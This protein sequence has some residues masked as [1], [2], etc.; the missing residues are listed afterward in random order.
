MKIVAILL[1]GILILLAV[2]LTRST[3]PLTES[4]PDPVL[5]F[6]EAL[7][8][9]SLDTVP[10]LAVGGDENRYWYIIWSVRSAALMQDS[11]LVSFDEVR[12]IIQSYD[13]N[14]VH[15]VTWGAEG[16]G[17]GEFKDIRS[18]V[19]PDGR[20][21]V[22]DGGNW[23]FTVFDSDG[24][25]E[26]DFA[27]RRLREIVPGGAIRAGQAQCRWFGSRW[28]ESETDFL[29]S[30]P[31]MGSVVECLPSGQD[32]LVTVSAVPVGRWMVN[33]RGQMVPMQMSMERHRRKI[34]SADQPM[35]VP[36]VPGF[37]VPPASTD[38]RAPG[39]SLPIINGNWADPT[40][41]MW[42]HLAGHTVIY[43]PDGTPI[44]RLPRVQGRILGVQRNV[45]LT[46]RDIGELPLIEVWRFNE[47]LERR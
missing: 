34:I 5:A 6:V 27:A 14:G 47:P 20:I 23:R 24:E 1:V 11:I 43:E 21:W 44:A 8:V 29:G 2:D 12:R 39:F 19:G 18:G 30:V 15:R 37:D 25:L 13:R 41:V 33:D 3:V 45:I 28:A 7:P 35:E 16:E 36:T 40:E 9:A 38:A 32:T 4:V 46:A 42:T 26:D 17:P 31:L 22:W 10:E